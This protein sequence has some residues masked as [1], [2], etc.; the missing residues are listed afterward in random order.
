MNDKI[1]LIG[2]SND[3]RNFSKEDIL[4]YKDK[5]YTIFSYSDSLD[6]FIRNKITPDYFTFLDPFTLSHYLNDFN[7]FNFKNT[8]LI[9]P[10]IY[11]NSFSN[12]FSLGYTCN[13]LKKDENL[14]SNVKKLNFDQIFNEHITKKYTRLDLND[15]INK[16]YKE[17]YY[18]P[19]NPKT[20]LCKYSYI[21][22]PLILN[23]FQ[24]LK[25]IKSIGF[26]H[27]SQ[28]RYYYTNP[29][30][31][32]HTG[33]GYKEYKTTYNQI[34][35]NIK[36]LLNKHNIKMSFDGTESHFKELIT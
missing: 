18:F 10:D 29:G 1:L 24:D 6:F 17:T 36:N 31:K 2:P 9:T 14:Y 16:D 19:T 15:F 22:I 11:S 5:G 12:F 35:K 32:Q 20:N 27:F 34:K 25:E 13:K 30:K 28:G 23:H 7:T 26:G 8:I 3:I 21:L 33:D 4:E